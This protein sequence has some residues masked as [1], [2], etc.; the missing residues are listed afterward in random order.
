MTEITTTDGRW[1]TI[2]I[3]VAAVIAVAFGVVFWFWGAYVWGWSA[4]VLRGLQ[5]GSI[6]HLRASG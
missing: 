3:V 5:A 2:D 1:R 6:R 4:A